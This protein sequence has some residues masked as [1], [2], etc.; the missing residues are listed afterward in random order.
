[1]TVNMS[2]LGGGRWR[3]LASLLIFTILARIV[4]AE[5]EVIVA[6]D[7]P[8]KTQYH[9]ANFN[10]S[11]YQYGYE[12]G[13]NGQFHH[14]TR[15]PDG[16]TY[17]CYGYIDPN[18]QLRVTHY[19]ADTHG[20]RVVEPNRPVEIFVDA[21]TQYSNSIA[22]EEPQ[23]RRRGELR[24]WTELY[25]PKGCGMFPGGMRPDGGS[26][27]A[28]P[29]TG[30]TTE[31]PPVESSPSTPIPGSPG[32]AI[33]VYPPTKPIDTSSPPGSSS[34]SSSS[35]PPSMPPSGPPS[36]SGG[37]NYAP[38]PNYQIAVSQYPY[39]F[40]P[41]PY[42]PPNVPQAP[43]NCPADQQN[44]QGGQQPNQPAGYLGFIPVLYIPN[45]HA[46][47]SGLPA[48]FNWPAPPPPEGFGQSLDELPA[49]R[50]FQKP[51]GSWVLQRARNRSRRL[52]ARRPAARRIITDQEYPAKK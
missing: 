22:E 35:P 13:P 33:G 29:P 1:M 52:R 51:D 4:R 18:G 23:E 36:S 16:V 10:T 42:A 49:Q 47:K 25:L 45:C 28:S 44:Q 2:P 12:V 9:E 19:V 27:G 26:G 30:P 11:S 46:Q 17:G 14:E 15:G 32:T 7:E 40:V 6:I 39:F 3:C 5:Q 37:D 34:S 41:Y 31:Q 43:C 38:P 8:G 21:P 48:N 50:L 20:Y 24:P